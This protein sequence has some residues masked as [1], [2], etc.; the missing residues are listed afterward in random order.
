MTNE[1]RKKAI[2]IFIKRAKC[3]ATSVDDI[4]EGTDLKCGETACEKCPLYY[5]D[6]EL[7][8]AEKTA[9]KALE[10]EPCDDAISRKAV[11]EYIEGSGAELGH[12]S[13]NELVCQ[14]IKE[15]PPVIPAREHG[16]WIPVSSGSLPDY[17]ERVLIQLECERIGYI[18][19]NEVMKYDVAYRVD[20]KHPM[21]DADYYWTGKMA[22][23]PTDVIAW[24]LPEP[25]NEKGAE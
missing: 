9:S 7:Y 1:E 19:D 11:L 18:D 6:D 24:Q 4:I 10:Q 22:Y 14:D 23:N 16:E 5:V 15:L 13:E 8:E 17:G 25:Y 3:R 20:Y 2:D 12:S 21:F